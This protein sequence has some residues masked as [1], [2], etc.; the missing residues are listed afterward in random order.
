MTIKDIIFAALRY[1]L[2]ALV[3]LLGFI[4]FWTKMA[5]IA[6]GPPY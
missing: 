5:V 2:P 6:S 3:L 1:G 4:W